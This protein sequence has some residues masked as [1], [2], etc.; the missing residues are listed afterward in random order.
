[1]HKKISESISSKLN[2]QS[3]QYLYP[4]HYIPW[5]DE[6]GAGVRYKSLNWGLE[7]LCYQEHIRLIV[8]SLSPQSVIDVGCGDGRFIGSLS[9]IKKKI[10]IDLEPRAINLAKALNSEVEFFCVGE[11]DISDVSDVAVAIE[12]LEHIPD[13]DVIEFIKYLFTKVR[14]GGHVI[15]SVPS[16][17]LPLNKKHYRHYTEDLLKLQLISAGVAYS[18]LSMDRIYREP[19]WLKLYL[20]LTINK[21]WV[22]EPIFFRRFVWRRL[23]ARCRYADKSN[24][25]HIVAVL[26]KA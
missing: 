5:L 3:R 20:K 24:G 8:E 14:D 15:I 18:D 9:S 4:Y 1:M 26:K 23:W 7:Y 22:F 10:G 2:F 21:Y 12:V 17:V 19:L 25:Y 13:D 6:K 11:R 16:T